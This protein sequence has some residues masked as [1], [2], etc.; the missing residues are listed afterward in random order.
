[1][2]GT[3]VERIGEYRL[4]ENYK[5]KEHPVLGKSSKYQVPLM[6]EYNGKR[7]IDIVFNDENTVYICELKKSTSTEGIFRCMSEILTYYFLMQEHIREDDKERYFFKEC[8]G[9]NYNPD[10]EYKLEPAVICPSSFITNIDIDKV[11]EKLRQV[12]NID[13]KIVTIH[14]DCGTLDE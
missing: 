9:D 6:R 13:L 2:N 14:D 7:A 4:Y 3:S 1:M 5:T 8:F 10:M 12:C 11:L